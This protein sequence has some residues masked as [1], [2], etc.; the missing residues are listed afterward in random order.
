MYFITFLRKSVN[1]EKGMGRNM[2]HVNEQRVFLQY[3]QEK[4]IFYCYLRTNQYNEFFPGAFAI[5]E[6][7]EGTSGK[8]GV[9]Y[10]LSTLR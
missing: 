9:Y 1:L 4:N 10:T 3:Q 5:W 7:Q 6:R 8:R 2:L